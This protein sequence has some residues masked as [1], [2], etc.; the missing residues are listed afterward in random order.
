MQRTVRL[1]RLS[2]AVAF[3][4]LLGLSSQAVAQVAN[5]E[6]RGA[7]KDRGQEQLCATPWLRFRPDG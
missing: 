1:I 7:V 4:G 3:V 2:A 5:A 6:L